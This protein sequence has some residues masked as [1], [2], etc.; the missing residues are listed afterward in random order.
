M[1]ATKNDWKR[2]FYRNGVPSEVIVIEDTPPPQ[3]EQ[4]QQQEQ[5]QQQITHT[6]NRPIRRAQPTIP[7]LLGPPAAS[8]RSKRI[9]KDTPKNDLPPPPPPPPVKRRKKDGTTTKH[10]KTFLKKKN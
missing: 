6:S 2:E 4:Q 10:I 1:T 5:R 8:T 3:Q 9:R 7:Y